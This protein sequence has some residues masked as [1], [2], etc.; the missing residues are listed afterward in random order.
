[1]LTLLALAEETAPFNC[2]LYKPDLADVN[3]LSA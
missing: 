2:K 3:S 1:M